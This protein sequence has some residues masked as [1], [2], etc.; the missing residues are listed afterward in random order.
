VTTLSGKAGQGGS[1]DGTGAAARFNTPE[2]VAVDSVGNVYVAD[3]SNFTIHKITP[4]GV[5]TTLAGKA[6]QQGHSA[7]YCRVGWS[8][9]DEPPAL[10]LPCTADRAGRDVQQGSERD[11]RESHGKLQDRPNRSRAVFL[12]APLSVTS[13]IMRCR[14]RHKPR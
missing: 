5:V 6:G 9:R 13:A 12:A 2:G 8:A 11:D 7:E 14:L 10:R 1:V 4:T 3:T